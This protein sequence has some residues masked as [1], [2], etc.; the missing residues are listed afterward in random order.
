MTGCDIIVA[1]VI[2]IS[3]WR[4]ELISWSAGWFGQS[5]NKWELPLALRLGGCGAERRW[6][7]QAGEMWKSGLNNAW[8]LRTSPL[9][10]LHIAFLP[11]R[12]N[13][14]DHFLSLLAQRRQRLEGVSYYWCQSQPSTLT[15]AL[16]THPRL[17]QSNKARSFSVA[18]FSIHLQYIIVILILRCYNYSSQMRPWGGRQSA[19]ILH[20]IYMDKWA[21]VLYSWPK[22]WIFTIIL[23][24]LIFLIYSMVFVA[25]AECIAY[26]PLI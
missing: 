12:Q 14:M 22:T 1:P 11:G 23:F 26:L 19:Q 13:K 8:P 18:T 15:S 2:C 21:Q 4:N 3:V 7:E 9:R 17:L 20:K 24:L 6:D 5:T 25:I 16:W 10:H